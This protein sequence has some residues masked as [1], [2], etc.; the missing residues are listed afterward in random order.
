MDPWA[1]FAAA[2]MD[3]TQCSHSNVRF[4]MRRALARFATVPQNAHHASDGGHAG[5]AAVPASVPCALASLARRSSASISTH[6]STHSSQMYTWGPAMS[7]RTSASPFLQNEHRCSG[8]RSAAFFRPSNMGLMSAPHRVQR[9]GSMC[10]SSASSGCSAALQWTWS[11]KPGILYA[12]DE[13]RKEACH[14]ITRRRVRQP[15]L[16]RA[17]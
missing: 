15:A 1:S 13:R 9:R 12:A 16:L 8:A 17:E 3:R 6:T 14:A 5:R 2:A 7:F 10:S 4:S 11:S